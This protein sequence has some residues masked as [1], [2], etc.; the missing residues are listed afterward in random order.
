MTRIF[1]CDEGSEIELSGTNDLL[2]AGWST[3]ECYGSLPELNGQQSRLEMDLDWVVTFDNH[4]LCEVTLNLNEASWGTLK[5]ASSCPRKSSESADP[6]EANGEHANARKREEDAKL[7]QALSA[8]LQAA[9]Q[10]CAGVR[11][12]FADD[13]NP[14]TPPSCDPKGLLKLERLNDVCI[15]AEAEIAKLNEAG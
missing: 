9:L 12:G 13:E 15:A 7:A 4:K 14:L 6:D 8:Q 2:E 5:F 1:S 10:K 11:V 3:H